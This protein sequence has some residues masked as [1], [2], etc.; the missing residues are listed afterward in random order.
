MT[1]R[2]GVKKVKKVEAK[3]IDFDSLKPQPIGRTPV[4]PSIQML[5]VEKKTVSTNILPMLTS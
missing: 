3:D 4:H 1:D 5:N 2:P